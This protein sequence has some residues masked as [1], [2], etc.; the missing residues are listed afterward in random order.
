MKCRECGEEPPEGLI[1]GA[2]IC[3]T[4]VFALTRK[5]KSIT[6]SDLERVKR[7]VEL[8]TAGLFPP[9]TLLA[10]VRGF[11]A[12]VA[13]GEVDREDLDRQM[14]N[15]L[16][17]LGGLG[18]CREMNKFAGTLRDV[19]AKVTEGVDELVVK[20]EEEIRRKVRILSDLPKKG[21]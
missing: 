15:E 21:P 4:C 8:E 12:A 10:L 20:V 7:E 5:P 9:E 18:M 6:R 1:P 13:A 19:A 2:R 14:C 11:A 16:Q 17:R 3:G